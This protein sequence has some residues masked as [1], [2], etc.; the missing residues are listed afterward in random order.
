MMPERIGSKLCASL[1]ETSR[2][3]NGPLSRFARR[4]L[5]QQSTEPPRGEAQPEQHKEPEQ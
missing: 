1:D 2:S 5:E 4:L 3:L